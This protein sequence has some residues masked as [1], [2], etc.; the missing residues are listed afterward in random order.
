ME[1]KIKR[2]IG[3]IIIAGIILIAISLT[4]WVY[5]NEG[6]KN[7]NVAKQL[8]EDGFVLDKDIVFANAQRL[9]LSNGKTSLSFIFK[10]D[11][12][13]QISY[14]PYEDIKKYHSELTYSVSDGLY[15]VSFVPTPQL[16]ATLSEEQLLNGLICEYS[17]TSKSKCEIVGVKAMANQAKKEYQSFLKRIK[18]S[19]NQMIAWAKK[20]FN[21]NT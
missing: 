15:K 11:K 20:Y 13:D 1:K 16:Q 9:I 6:T 19:E 10:D 7:S 17:F 18:L 5:V 14:A 4:T 2:K 21:Q 12:V 8:K 3:L